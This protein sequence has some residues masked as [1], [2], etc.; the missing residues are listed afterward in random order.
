MPRTTPPSQDPAADGP[1]SADPFDTLAAQILDTALTLR[2]DGK[3]LS[4]PAIAEWVSLVCAQARADG[5]P[6]ERLIVDLK[7]RWF[8]SSN[9]ASYQDKNDVV[10]DLVSLCIREYYRDGDGSR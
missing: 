4:N 8:A 7:S 10:P 5:Q 3:S 2:G 6:P 1:S 9:P